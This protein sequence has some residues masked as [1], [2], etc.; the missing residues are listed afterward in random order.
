MQHEWFGTFPHILC[1][2]W[3]LN[4]EVYAL[5]WEA[6]SVLCCWSSNCVHRW[7]YILLQ[8]CQWIASNSNLQSLINSSCD[9]WTVSLLKRL[10][11]DIYIHTYISIYKCICAHVY[12]CMCKQFFFFCLPLTK[13]RC[14]QLVSKSISK[15]VGACN[16]ATTAPS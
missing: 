10:V 4:N 13:R 11:L 1:F 9:Y 14:C 2:L 6:R 12:V 5:A 16:I 8:C 3:A 7:S 15:P